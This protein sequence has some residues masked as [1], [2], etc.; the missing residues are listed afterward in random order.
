MTHLQIVES[1]LQSF[2]V[3]GYDGH[4]GASFSKQYGKL[5]AKTSRPSS[6]ITMLCIVQHYIMKCPRGN[7]FPFGSHFLFENRGM[8]MTGASKTRKTANMWE[9]GCSIIRWL[10]HANS[11]QLSMYT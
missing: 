4:M 1:L 2:L 8:N 11:V 7:T 3:P 6:N 10:C 9:S 5:K